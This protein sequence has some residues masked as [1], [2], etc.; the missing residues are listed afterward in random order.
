M[1]T[2]REDDNSQPVTG[3]PP[4]WGRVVIPDSPA[5]LASESRRVRRELRWAARRRRWAGNGSLFRSPF[6]ILLI[7]LVLALSSLFSMVG[8][9]S[10]APRTSGPADA[11]LTLTG[12]TLVDDLGRSVRIG[13][14]LPAA[15]LILDSCACAELAASVAGAAP[16]GVAVLLVSRQAPTA[17]GP[18]IHLADPTGLVRSRA[19]AGAATADMATVVLL[20]ATGRVTRLVPAT[21]TI[22]PFQSELLALHP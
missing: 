14:H 7:T 3:L 4:E 6:A 15:I 11:D 19:G 22:D 18:G 2:W 8:P 5:E 16:A 12:V 9:L 13:Q 20:D 1:A 17:S 21:A 10:R